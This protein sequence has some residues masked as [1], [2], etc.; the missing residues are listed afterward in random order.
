MQ[1]GRGTHQARLSTP[2][3]RAA[4]ARQRPG[5]LGPSGAAERW[6]ALPAAEAGSACPLG[7]RA[8]A[9]AAPNDGGDDVRRRRPLP[10]GTP[11]R[12]APHRCHT[13]STRPERAARRGGR[14][15]EGRAGA[16]VGAGA[17]DVPIVVVLLAVI[18]VRAGAPARPGSQAGG[19]RGARGRDVPPRRTWHSPW[20]RPAAAHGAAA[21]LSA[22]RAG[23]SKAPLRGAAGNALAVCSAHA[24]VARATVCLMTQY[25][26]SA[27]RARTRDLRMS[28]L[29]TSVWCAESPLL[30]TPLPAPAPAPSQAGGRLPSTCIAC[31]RASPLR[32]PPGFSSASHAALPACRCPRASA[33]PVGRADRG[34]PAAAALHA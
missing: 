9:P 10:R 17:L 25:Q 2:D 23:D 7:A 22:P 31:T 33:R 34:A 18:P 30:S 21:S 32:L 20:H 8:G 28:E 15:G 11:P 19:A 27:L 4:R 3:L 13:W 12:H 6:C 5:R 24:S 29:S 14:A 26:S 16:H 1:P